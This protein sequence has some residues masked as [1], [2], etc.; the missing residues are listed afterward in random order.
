VSS[1]NGQPDVIPMASAFGGHSQIAH[2]PIAASQTFEIGDILQIAS[3]QLKISTDGIGAEGASNVVSGILIAAEPAR[4]QPA[5]L[6]SKTANTLVAYYRM[7]VGDLVAAY[8]FST[9]GA[10]TA[11]NVDATTLRG[12]PV[13]FVIDGSGNWFAD[14]AATKKLGYVDKIFGLTTTGAGLSRVEDFTST[15][16][17]AG[18][19]VLGIRIA[20][21]IL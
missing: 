14:T 13:G 11:A 3:A 16:L 7:N 6:S 10:G 21:D 8:R 1:H 18:T 2:S 19:F 17:T 5:N 15:A 4:I 9:D 12:K 20:R